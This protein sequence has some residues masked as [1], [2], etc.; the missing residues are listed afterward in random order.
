MTDADRITKLE[1]HVTRLNALVDGYAELL[2][3]ALTVIDIYQDTKP[4]KEDDKG[5]I[6]FTE[7]AKTLFAGPGKKGVAA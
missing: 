4:A 7:Y 5:F 6:D 1:D 3:K 2:D